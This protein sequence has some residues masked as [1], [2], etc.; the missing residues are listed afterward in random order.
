M[1]NALLTAA[2]APSRPQ[3]MNDPSMARITHLLDHGFP[4]MQFPQPLEQQFLRD[5]GEARRRHFILSGLISLIIFNGFLIVDYL[6]VNDVFWMALQLRVFLFT[7]LALVTLYAFSDKSKPLARLV[8]PVG[9]E[10]VVLASGLAAAASLAFILAE[11]RSPLA[12]FYH[13]G[14]IV[15]IMYGNLVQRL[16]FWYAL[17]FS[18]ALLAIHVAGIVLLDNFPD[19]LMWPIVSLVAS[20]AC[21]SLA[22]NYAME[23]DERRRYLLTRRE[24]G[25]VQELTLA[26]ERLKELS[27]IDSLTGL[28]NRRHFQEHLRQTWD[29]AQYDGDELSILMVD[30]DHFKKYNDRYGHPAGDE[31]LRQVA[32]VLRSNLHR[33][34]DLVVRY[35]GEEFIAV[36]P[37]TSASYALV[38]AERIRQ[39]VEALQMRHESSS[40]ALVVTVS[41]GVSSCRADVLLKD[42]QVIAAADHALYR[43]KHEGRNRICAEHL[44]A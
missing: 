40:T 1:N 5:I 12:H 3:A 18:L 8:P 15:V 6:M 13:V 33:P 31:C 7:P 21:F 9:L 35:G 32:E 4:L 39:A 27:R 10:T 16:R 25:L 36:L 29:R 22:A 42:S 26:H 37:R 2:P 41:I 43:A 44:S 19:R 30:V 23:R 17:V 14:F 24:R 34:D 11:S 20:T 28:Y 38:V